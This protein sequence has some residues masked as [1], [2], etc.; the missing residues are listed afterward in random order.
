[1]NENQMLQEAAA[2]IKTLRSQNQLMR[3]RLDMFDCMMTVL[4]TEPA[5][6][7]DGLMSPDIVWQIEKHLEAEKTAT[8]VQA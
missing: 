6:R 2:E 4:H 1:M 8:K 5:R 7:G 3:A